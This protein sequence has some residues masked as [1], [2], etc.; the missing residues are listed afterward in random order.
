[1]HSGKDKLEAEVPLWVINDKKDLQLGEEIEQ[2]YVTSIITSILGI[3]TD[4]MKK[5]AE[6]FYRGY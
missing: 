1:M 4:E 3:G 2:I 6:T 5:R